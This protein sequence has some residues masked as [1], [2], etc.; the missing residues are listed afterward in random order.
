MGR[1]DDGTDVSTFNNI[2]FLA[3]LKPAD[4]WRPQFHGKKEELIAAIQKKFQ[5]IPGYRFQLLA[6]YPGQRR[7]G[8]VRRERGKLPQAFRRR[9][10]YAH[11]TANKITGLMNKVRGVTDVGVFN[12]ERSTQPD[13]LH[14]SCAGRALRHCRGRYEQ[15]RAGGRR[16]RA[17]DP[18][19][20][21]RP[22]L[23]F[24]RAIIPQFRNTPEAIRRILL[25][26]PDGNQVPLGNV[27]N[28]ALRNGA[29]M[30]YREGGRRYIPIKFSVR[31]RDLPAPLRS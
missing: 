13:R 11:A 27:A 5:Q 28:V 2:E 23:R 1:P 10:R 7:R 24:R 14:R 29:F 20:R 26:T 22:A 6:K 25:P 4:E 18:D 30:I 31:G 16:R 12:V 8:D 3:D 15:H 17:G 9:F 21:G 19:H